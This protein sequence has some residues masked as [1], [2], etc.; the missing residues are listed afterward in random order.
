M[1][2]ALEIVRGGLCAAKHNLLAFAGCLLGLGRRERDTP[3]GSAGASRQASG[4]DGRGLQGLG[5]EHRHEQGVN[6]FGR[7]LQ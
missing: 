1:Q 4:N 3:S 5:I 2:H 7:N 6:G